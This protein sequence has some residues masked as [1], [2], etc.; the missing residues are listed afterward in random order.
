MSE[1]ALELSKKIKSMPERIASSE[2]K[3]TTKAK[4]KIFPI[5][6]GCHKG[7]AES[8]L[9]E[10]RDK[11][12]EF[13]PNTCLLKDIPDVKEMDYNT[14][15]KHYINDLRSGGSYVFPIIYLH[16]SLNKGSGVGLI[17]EIRDITDHIEYPVLLKSIVLQ[18]QETK[19][20]EHVTYIPHR[21]NI[22]NLNE[23]SERALNHLNSNL[24]WIKYKMLLKVS[25]N[26]FKGKKYPSNNRGEKNG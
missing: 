9:K 12:K 25:Q 13:Y 4:E 26:I 11:L 19:T 14:K 10:I 2:D 20:F 7:K 21:K 15:F 3:I 24:K 1:S 17:N 5:V 18:Y 16:P 6:L 23:C 8:E 22:N